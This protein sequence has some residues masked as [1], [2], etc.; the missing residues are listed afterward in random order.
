MT[1]MEDYMRGLD[2]LFLSA[3]AFATLTQSLG[4]PFENPEIPTAQ[5][6]FD[7]RTKLISFELNPDFI[8]SLDDGQVAAVLAHETY[9][10]LLDHFDEQQ[11]RKSYPDQNALAIAHECIINDALFSNVGFH[12]PEGHCSG[13]ADHGQDFSW[14]TTK[15]GYDFLTEPPEE[16]EDSGGSSAEGQGTGSG[17]GSDSEN[18][19]ESSDS[20]ESGDGNSDS[21]GDSD[22]ESEGDGSDD[23]DNDDSE[24]DKSDSAKGQPC[25]GIKVK[26]EDEQEFK[27]AISRGV[28]N[29]LNNMKPEEIDDNLSDMLDELSHVDGIEIDTK[30]WSVNEVDKSSAFLDTSDTLEL[31]WKTLLAKINPAIMTSRKPQYKDSWHQPRRKML[32]SYP[33]IV[34]PSVRRKDNTDG[35][36][37]AVP[38]FILALDMSYSIPSYLI[39]KLASL[40]DSI[41]TD[42][43]HP[44]PVTWSDNVKEFDT[45]ERRIVNRNGTNVSELYVW[46]DKHAKATRTKPYVLV[47]TDGEC[48]FDPYWLSRSGLVLDEKM[49]K[50]QWIWMAIEPGDERVIQRNFGRYISKHPVYCMQDFM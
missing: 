31:N 49:L 44:T 16:D 21:S 32:N 18:S 4:R 22:D 43:I 5:V 47:I 23:S 13:P 48:N 12:L 24:E 17:A 19:D 38:T 40:A 6:S 28:E 27:D 8:K 36:G 15:E 39:G 42:I 29:A 3:K 10:V 45:T 33:E 30:G 41:P 14:F 34:L 1:F 2:S 25:G 37:D 35:R 26:A 20:D 9:H 46:A 11:D 7:P 50:E